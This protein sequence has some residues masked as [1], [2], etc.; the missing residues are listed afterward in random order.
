MDTPVNDALQR[1]LSI[2]NLVAQVGIIV[3]GG[4][5]RVTGSGLGCS[6]WPMCEPGQFAPVFHEES[7][8]H[9]IIEF[10]NRTLTGVLG[11][12][13][14]ALIWS[15]YR[16]SAPTRRDVR[17]YAWAVLALIIV[18]AVV[19]G[20]SVWVTLHP[21]VVGL[22]MA[23]SLGL[24]SLST[25]LVYRLYRPRATD[26][27]ALPRL[28]TSLHVAIAAVKVAVAI[29]GVVV[30][31]TGPHS[32]DADKPYRF[33][34]DPLFITRIH[35]G[36]AWV[37]VILVAIATYLV[38]KR[39]SLA[40]RPWLVV[41]GVLLAQGLLGY[42]QYFTGLHPALVVAHMLGS[43]LTVVAITWAIAR[44]YALDTRSNSREP[45]SR[46]GL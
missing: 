37:L 31:G 42:I 40:A 32:G 15:L 17:P 25:Y 1:R 5:V 46:L 4:A 39:S 16:K 35:A 7:T 33:A 34:I 41:V 11:I 20:I 12:I 13:A 3:T 9:P 23:L 8:W 24:V 28:E 18:Q 45:N 2:A 22:H 30:T 6:T 26:P 43:G 10:G 21:A 38:A 27:A 14:L 29:I 19:G 36:A 44:S